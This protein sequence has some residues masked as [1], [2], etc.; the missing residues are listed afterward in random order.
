MWVDSR[1]RVSCG[2]ILWNTTLS[3]LVL[4][5]LFVI[6]NQNSVGEKIQRWKGTEKLSHLRFPRKSIRG[7][8]ESI[9]T[10]RG[11]TSLILKNVWFGLLPVNQDLAI[12]TIDTGIRE[13][14]KKNLSLKSYYCSPPGLRTF[15]KSEKKW[16]YGSTS[17]V[18]HPLHNFQPDPQEGVNSKSKVITVSL[19][20]LGKVYQEDW[21]PTV[22]SSCRFLVVNF[23]INFEEKVESSRRKNL[24]GPGNINNLQFQYVQSILHLIPKVV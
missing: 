15:W 10:S 22:L 19:H 11:I 12:V 17:T 1:N 4:P 23:Q 8:A 20:P 6:F 21:K 24:K 13:L 16:K 18:S 9:A 3:I 5:D 7:T 2:D 14:L